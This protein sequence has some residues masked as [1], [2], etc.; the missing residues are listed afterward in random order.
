MSEQLK[1]WFFRDLT[2]D[3]RLKLFGL[4][5]LPIDEIGPHHGRQSMALRH[6]TQRLVEMIRDEARPSPQTNAEPVAWLRHGEKVPVQGCPFGA[7]WISDKNDPRAFPV[8]TEQP[9]P[10][11][12]LVTGT[13]PVGYATKNE[14]TKLRLGA[15][16]IDL[17][18]E[19][20]PKG[21]EMVPLY[22]HPPAESLEL[23][24]K[25][26]RV[27]T[28]PVSTEINPR[29]YNIRTE[30]G[31]AE[32]AVELIKEALASQ[33]P[34]QS[35]EPFAWT[36][37]H[38]DEDETH[39]GFARRHPGFAS[40]SPYEV[41][42]LSAGTAPADRLR[43]DTD[44]KALEAV[45]AIFADL[46]D[47]RFVKWLFDRRGDENLI[48]RLDDGEELRG[49]DLEV[50]GQIKAAWQVIIAKALAAASEGTE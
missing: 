5:G 37:K 44:A 21:F 14:L 43:G 18:G 34:E 26:E 47:R 3:Q 16:C 28:Y 33:P 27:L 40:D 20:V 12:Q 48:G 23:L 38:P 42:A 32:Y 50:Q 49:L 25:L 4:F 8:Y 30:R 29:G 45:E 2:D 13:A 46:R 22:A 15:S 36:W 11:S 1:L 39:R 7:M 6:I 24:E 19:V 41:M 9:L 31:A 17:F 35:A 10:P